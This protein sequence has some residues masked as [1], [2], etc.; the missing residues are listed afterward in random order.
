[1]A[2]NGW[3]KSGDIGYFDE[4]GFLYVIDRKKEVF[5]YQG[6]QI[7]PIEIEEII[8][9]HPDVSAVC[10]TCIPDM[11]IFTDLPVALVMKKQGS[12]VTEEELIEYTNSRVISEFKKL[13]AGVY[14]VDN[15]PLTISGKVQRKKLQQV[16][17][18]E[19][20]KKKS[21]A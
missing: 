12:N 1:M 3:I 19:Y 9:K 21:Q 5:K 4:D 17:I 20:N 2:E 11:E 6:Y 10:V 8:E 15:F 18:E 13:R 7:F 16:A 14:F